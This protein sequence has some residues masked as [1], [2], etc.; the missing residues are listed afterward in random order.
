MMALAR[1]RRCAGSSEPLLFACVVVPFYCKK[2]KTWGILN[3]LS[4][5]FKNWVNVVLVSGNV[6]TRCRQYGNQYKS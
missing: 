5:F 1:Q 6:F 4:S 2:L 3:L